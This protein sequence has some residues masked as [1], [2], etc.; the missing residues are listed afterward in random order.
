M[1]VIFYYL[2]CDNWSGLADNSFQRS[3]CLE[4]TPS[5][6]TSRMIAFINAFTG[7]GGL[8]GLL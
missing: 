5:S 6:M 4:L 2:S 3:S 8:L 1:L 7:L